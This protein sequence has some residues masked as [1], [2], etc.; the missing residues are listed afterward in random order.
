MDKTKPYQVILS[1][2]VH[3]N[4]KVTAKKLGITKGL[5]I[6]FL[7]VSLE[8]RLTKYRNKIGFLESARSD[9]LDAKLMKFIILKDSKV[10]PVDDEV[11]LNKIKLDY[12]Y[13]NNKPDFT[14]VK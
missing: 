11:I 5:F 2:H 12:E 14:F 6:Q 10:L 1:E 4:I 8:D 9:E 13:L 3:K 7:Y